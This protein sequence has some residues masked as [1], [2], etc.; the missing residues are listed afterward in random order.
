VSECDREA[1]IM[2]R[3]RHTRCVEPLE[4]KIISNEVCSFAPF[5]HR[6]AKSQEVVAYIS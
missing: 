5:V 6:I 2:R 3:P 4:K 1:S